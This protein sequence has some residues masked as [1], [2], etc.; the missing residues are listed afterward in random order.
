M[1]KVIVLGDVMLDKTVNVRVSHFSPESEHAPVFK[2]LNTKYSPGGAAN[3]A[4]GVKALGGNVTLFGITAVD[5]ANEELKY[6]LAN[7]D[8]KHNFI[9]FNGGR[10]TVKERIMSSSGLILRIDLEEA[11][12]LS[13]DYWRVGNNLHKFLLEELVDTPVVVLVDYDKGFFSDISTTFLMD[14]LKYNANTIVVDPG[15]NGNWKRFSSSKT[16]FKA[17]LKQ[18]ISYYLENSKSYG[19]SPPINKPD[20]YSDEILSADKMFEL[21]CRMRSN[22]FSTNT[23]FQYVVITAGHSGM[24]V[25]SNDVANLPH[26][27]QL[28]PVEVCDP[29]GAGDTVLAV[30]AVNVDNYN[31]FREMKDIC[32]YAAKAARIAVQK[33]GVS[34][35]TRGMLYE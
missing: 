28:K 25:A 21:G 9:H 8:I 7:K 17:N 5:D 15:R 29:C 22:L 1:K 14:L 27:V 23:E 13:N 32:D 30:I 34:V 33:Q 12:V 31:S 2:Y 3:V 11:G 6:A 26:V 10:T 24:V 16:I 35:I 20:E 4:A 18:S 19:L